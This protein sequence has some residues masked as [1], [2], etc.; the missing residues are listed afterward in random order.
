MAPSPMV[1]LQPAD[2][3]PKPEKKPFV[4]P[5]HAVLVV[6]IVLIILGSSVI[7]MQVLTSQK[8]RITTRIGILQTTQTPTPRPPTPTDSLDITKDWKTYANKS[9][10]LKYPSRFTVTE[11]KPVL[12]SLYPTIYSSVVFTDETSTITIQVAKNTQKLTLTNALGNGPILRYTNTFIANKSTRIIPLDDTDAILIEKISAGQLGASMNVIGIKDEKVYEL[13]V[14]PLEVDATI[15]KLMLSTF[16]ILGQEPSD[17]TDDWTVR[18]DQAYGFSFK[19]PTT[20][21]L[22]FNKVA[23]GSPNLTIVYDNSTYQ[24]DTAKFKIEVQDLKFIGQSDTTS[25]NII[26][27]PLSEYVNKKWDLNKTA[28]VSGIH[29]VSPLL[30]TTIDG[31][32]AYQF[33]VDGKYVDDRGSETLTEEYLYAFTENA[34]YKYKIWYPKSSTVYDQIL[35]TFTFTK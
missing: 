17:E 14:T 25:R 1:I 18:I 16:K 26:Q 29:T 15:G 12:S 7:G 33:S 22:D 31:K 6:V 20:Y 30:Q 8:R 24:V 2:Q 23:S 3:A 5:K 19:Y 9:F 4:L 34:G 35:K 27:L 32:P 11:Q 21:S 13:T 10:S 28:S